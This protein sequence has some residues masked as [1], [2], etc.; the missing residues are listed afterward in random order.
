[1]T[2]DRVG[3]PVLPQEYCVAHAPKAGNND[4]SAGR[5]GI[6]TGEPMRVRALEVDSMA[7][8]GCVLLKVDVM[9][10]KTQP[11]V[12]LFAVGTGRYR[13]PRRYD[14]ST[15]GSKDAR[16]TLPFEKCSN[17]STKAS[18][19]IF[20]SRLADGDSIL[21]MY[22]SLTPQSAANCLFPSADKER[23]Y[24]LS[25]SMQSLFPVG[26]KNASPALIPAGN[27][28]KGKHDYAG[29]MKPKVYETRRKRLKLLVDALGTGGQTRAA[30]LIAET[31]GTDIGPSYV[32]RML[33]EKGKKGRKNISTD[34]AAEIE[35]A[36][37]RPQGWLSVDE[38]SGFALQL[39]TQDVASQWRFTVPRTVILQ[40]D[41]D[42]FSRLDRAVTQL[43]MEMLVEKSNRAS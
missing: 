35:K 37:G 20:P 23:R 7:Q 24:D 38:E 22:C 33:M 18:E 41:E 6:P 15:L 27:L 30:G 12:P 17:F 43:V 26:N 39:N 19:N 28:L 29:R 13:L 4:N 21:R 32:N 14:Q 5:A 9:A 34:M 2:N 8:R 1:M 11:W 42:R 31:R 25:A 10:K 40:L 36:F 16:G 3:S